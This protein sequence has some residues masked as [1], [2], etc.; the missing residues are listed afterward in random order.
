[1][2][3]NILYGFHDIESGDFEPERLTRAQRV[4]KR[5]R[6]DLLVLVEACFAIPNHTGIRMDY[7]KLF[8]YPYGYFA[9]WGEKGWGNMV[10]SR[11][12]ISGKRIPLSNRTALRA[13]VHIKKLSLHIDVFHPHPDISERGKIRAIIPLLRTKP[14][15]YVLTGDLNAISDEDHYD[16]RRLIAGFRRFAGRKA[17]KMVGNLWERKLIPFV[18]S[19]G[20]RDAFFDKRFR[21]FTMPSDLIN[22]HKESAIRIDH[23]F[24]S[25]DIEVEKAYVVKNQDTEYASDHYPICVVI[26]MQKR[27]VS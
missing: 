7:K 12:P 23:C 4:V 17:E 19:S 27:H 25:P 22:H 24:V 9:P 16:R 18:K 11:Y 14:I 15:P 20:L 6:P 2:T 8:G 3:Y 10:L 13:I 1:M 21:T 26:K 5:E